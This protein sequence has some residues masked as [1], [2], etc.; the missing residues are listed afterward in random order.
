MAFFRVTTGITQICCH[1]LVGNKG[2]LFPKRKSRPKMEVIRPEHSSTLY[3]SP[4]L[5]MIVTRS[6]SRLMVRAIA[7]QLY[8]LTS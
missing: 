3:S 2:S 5:N 8:M 1:D 7:A 6:Y 4:F